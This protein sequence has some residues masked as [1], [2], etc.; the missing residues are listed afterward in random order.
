[1]LHHE[2]CFCEGQREYF[3]ETVKRMAQRYGFGNTQLDQISEKMLVCY[4]AAHGHATPDRGMVDGL[5]ELLPETRR[6]IREA[7][8]EGVVVSECLNDFT[9]QWCD[10]SWDWNLLLPFPDP[11]FYTLPWLMGSHEIDALEYG[12]VN[13]AFAYKLHLDMK[14]DGG[15]GMITRYPEFAAHVKR[16]AELR[17]R[18]AEYYSLADFRGEEKLRVKGEGTALAKVYHNREAGKAGIVVAEISGAATAAVLEH[19]WLTGVAPI[20]VYSNMNPVES[21]GDPGVLH[22]QLLP[23][24]VKVACLDLA[25]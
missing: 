9:G 25:E 8:P 10:S 5:C 11:I 13:K 20:R 12:E 3:L 16:N 19:D 23:Y 1:M 24:E 21:V 14:I 7:N 6:L 2:I 22:L 17:R 18:V 15:D 4:N